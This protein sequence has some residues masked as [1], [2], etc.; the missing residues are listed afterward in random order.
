MA[1]L[2]HSLRNRLS[3]KSYY[4]WH[5]C[6]I[7][8]T[9]NFLLIRCCLWYFWRRDFLPRRVVYGISVASCGEETFFQDLFFVAFVSSPDEETF[10]Q[11]VLCVVF[12]SHALT[13]RFSAKTC[14]LWHFWFMP[15]Q[16]DFVPWR[17]S[18]GFSDHWVSSPSDE[19]TFC[20]YLLPVAA[21]YHPLINISRF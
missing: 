6:L 12:L 15:W 7:L 19:E 17:V 4:L 11:D 13:G 16:R 21:V 20:Q 1:A 5:L 9:R 10:C 14:C 8:W 2:S 18:C 3:A